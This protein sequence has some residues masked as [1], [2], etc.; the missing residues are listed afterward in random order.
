MAAT[1]APPACRGPMAC[2]AQRDSSGVGFSRPTALNIAAILN[3]P[4]CSNTF[5]LHHSHSLVAVSA[6]N[7]NA[8]S[9]TNYAPPAATLSKSLSLSLPNFMFIPLGVTF[10]FFLN[11]YL[12]KEKN[13]GGV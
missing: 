4:K 5:Q 10:F 9:V 11:I 2:K 12:W 13:F 1:A 6:A 7:D 3:K 8:V